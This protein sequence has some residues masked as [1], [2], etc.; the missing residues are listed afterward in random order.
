MDSEILKIHLKDIASQFPES[1]EFEEQGVFLSFKRKETVNSIDIRNFWIAFYKLNIDISKHFMGGLSQ[2]FT[3]EKHS[4]IV[5]SLVDSKGKLFHKRAFQT[6][7][8]PLFVFPELLSIGENIFF[9]GVMP[10]NRNKK[11]IL[12]ENEKEAFFNEINLL[13]FEI[14]EKMQKDIFDFLS[15]HNVPPE[16]VLSCT[17]FILNTDRIH[18]WGISEDEF[19]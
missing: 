13:T 19:F 1:Y 12:D 7:N 11:P 6:S 8:I 17:G 14:S 5:E 15:T 16:K 3:F 9:K 4:K 2:N 18:D 10:C